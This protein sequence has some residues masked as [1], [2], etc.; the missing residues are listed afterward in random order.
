MLGTFISCEANLS[1]HTDTSVRSRVQ[2]LIRS[3]LEPKR[4]SGWR[5][6]L[7]LVG[8]VLSSLLGSVLLWLGLAQSASSRQLVAF[9]AIFF[10]GAV[11]MLAHVLPKPFGGIA[12]R[13][14]LAALVISAV[15]VWLASGA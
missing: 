1:S 2:S 7:V 8:V 9:A 4:A 10:S 14:G 15:W 12:S 5:A 11:C 13:I 3:I 6:I